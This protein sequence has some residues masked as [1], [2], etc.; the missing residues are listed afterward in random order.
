LRTEP[1]INTI[2][3]EPG[4]DE[5]HTIHAREAVS[6]IQPLRKNG[7]NNMSSTGVSQ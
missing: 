1:T 5:Q 6:A 2:A 3:T 7:S 4:E